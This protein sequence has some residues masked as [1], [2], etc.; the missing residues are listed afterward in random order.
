MNPS[1]IFLKSFS[2]PI[3]CIGVDVGV[4]RRLRVIPDLGFFKIL[5]VHFLSEKG[6]L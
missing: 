4:E 1:G 6:I 2:H 3:S 5:G